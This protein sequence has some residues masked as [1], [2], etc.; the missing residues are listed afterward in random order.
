V[1]RDDEAKRYRQVVLSDAQLASGLSN[2]PALP[3]PPPDAEP[4][5][6]EPIAV[7]H[8]E[9]DD[10]ERRL[11]I[12][13]QESID[14]LDYLRLAVIDLADGIRV[15][16]IRHTRNQAPGT[17]VHI[18]PHQFIDVEVPR[19]NLFAAIDQIQDG[20]LQQI[21]DGLGLAPSDFSWKRPRTTA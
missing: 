11:N 3:P 4:V 18:L 6:W 14:D 10:L 7:L 19:Q 13:F 21:V 1:D 16:L 8:A 12:S 20:A 9:P 15:G 2:H 5:P 17:Q